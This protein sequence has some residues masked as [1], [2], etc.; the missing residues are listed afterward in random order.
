VNPSPGDV[1]ALFDERLGAYVAVQVTAVDG[2]GHAAVVLLDWVGAEPPAVEQLTALRPQRFD[3]FFRDGVEHH[4]VPARVPRRYVRVGTVAP[5]LTGDVH[6]HGGWPDGR[7]VWAQRRWNAF[8]QDVRDRFKAAV[9]SGEHIARRIDLADDAYPLATSVDTARPVPGLFDHLRRRH[10]VYEATLRGHGERV[11]D[12]R[13]THLTNLVLDVT[14][15]EEIHLGD[16]LT[17]LA[18]FGTFTP[19]L[20]VH[21]EDDGRWLSLIVTGDLSVPWTGLAAVESLLIR[22]FRELDG[23]TVT[24]RF[25]ALTSLSATGAPG[26]LRHLPALAALRLEH[27]DLTDV[28]GYGPEDF[29]DFPSLETLSL[30][31]IPA[32]VATSVTT[33]YRDR[34]LDVRQPRT[35]EW[36]AQN[37]DNPFRQWDGAEHVTAAQAKKAAGL[38]RKARAAALK[39]PTVPAL[40]AVATAYVE[41]FNAFGS[42]DTDAREQIM[43][44]LDDI[45]VAAGADP[46]DRDAIFG[47]ADR[48]RDF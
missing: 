27:L 21:A 26:Y 20:R 44:A 31:S 38:Y 34:D 24:T 5:L 46:A 19:G 6:A 25:P 2:D 18:L 23:H 39:T 11:V 35:P 17:S 8:P 36:L 29:P 16:D 4:W 13:G 40:T 30:T 22:A 7:A 41:G 9:L 42:I 45:L 10:L 32:D 43:A 28:F 12:L 3:Y 33:R 14:G 47:A 15:V 1:F 48:V 37:V